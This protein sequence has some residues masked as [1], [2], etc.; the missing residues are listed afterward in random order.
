[1]NIIPAIDLME[2]RC[3]RLKKGDFGQATFYPQTPIDMAKR[4]QKM[5]YEWL[6]IIDLD[7]A[8]EGKSKNQQTIREILS[9]TTLNIQV[10]GGIRR[11]EDISIFL[12]MGVARVILGSVA[13]K[14]PE[15]IQEAIHRF[16]TN[17]IVVS[18][19]I[20]DDQA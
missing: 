3:V 12:Q 17:R 15:V 16:G 11:L 6:H 19:D 14:A 1:M 5:G 8:R 7:G 20:R 4:L 13:L 18:M 9:Q 10:G 2:G